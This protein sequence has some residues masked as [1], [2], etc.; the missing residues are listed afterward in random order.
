M[1]TGLAGRRSAASSATRRALPRAGIGRNARAVV[2]DL[3]RDHGPDSSRPPSPRRGTPPAASTRRSPPPVSTAAA[4]GG[5][6]LRQ[7]GCLRLRSRVALASCARTHPRQSAKWTTTSRD[8]FR[9]CRRSAPQ[10]LR[11]CVAPRCGWCRPRERRRLPPRSSSVRACRRAAWYDAFS[12]RG[13]AASAPST[14]A[15]VCLRRRMRRPA[16]V[17]QS[18]SSIASTSPSLT[19]QTLP[20]PPAVVSARRLS[21]ADRFPLV[22]RDDTATRVPRTTT[23][24]SGAYPQRRLSGRD[25]RRP[26]VVWVTIRPWSM[27]GTSGPDPFASRDDG[28]DPGVRTATSRGHGT[29]SPGTTGGVPRTAHEP[30]RLRGRD[31]QSDSSGESPHKLCVRHASP[32]RTDR[33]VSCRQF[34]DGRLGEHGGAPEQSRR[35]RRRRPFQGEPGVRRTAIGI[36]PSPAKRCECALQFRKPA[37]IPPSG[38]RSV[39]PATIFA[40]ASTLTRSSSATSCL[41]TGPTAP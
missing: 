29:P 19:R 16:P 27:P 25:E 32:A 24:V 13:A 36:V 20:T 5:R 12:V 1:P 4:R 11:C 39:S 14:S 28:R 18:V 23:S 26:E 17:D 35:T 40:T 15:A 10:R 30:R 33:G 9:A 38:V 37:E 2:V 34:V 21:G 7:D 22:R 3:E 31:L 8:R 41:K 6:S